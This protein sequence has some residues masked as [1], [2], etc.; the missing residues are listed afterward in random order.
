MLLVQIKN[1][2]KGEEISFFFLF[3]LG[4]DFLFIKKNDLFFFSLI[5]FKILFSHFFSYYSY[6]QF[7]SRQ[8]LM[9]YEGFSEQMVKLK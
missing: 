2:V 5:F 8:L 9:T 6:T 1:C 7:K 3:S 4:W